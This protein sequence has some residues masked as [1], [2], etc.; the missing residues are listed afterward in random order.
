MSA[1]LKL[2]DELFTLDISKLD[3]K[4]K[5]QPH[6]DLLHEYSSIAYESLLG[7]TEAPYWRQS[8]ADLSRLF[9]LMKSMDSNPE[10]DWKK[11]WAKL[12]V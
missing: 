1:F 11:V 6:I 12:R 5:I 10:Q 2:Y 3:Q 9:D 8:A 4:A 7:H